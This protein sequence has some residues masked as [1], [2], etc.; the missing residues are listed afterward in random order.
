MLRAL[1]LRGLI[2]AP[3][4]LLALPSLSATGCSSTNGASGAPNSITPAATCARD[5]TVPPDLR[6]VERSG[7]G[8]VSTT[9]GEY[10]ARTPDWAR[11]GTVFSLLT[12]VW[13][14]TKSACPDLPKD[15]VKAL[16]AAV[17]SLKTSIAAKDQQ[18]AANA[19]NAVGI[20]VPSLFEYFN[21]DIPVE[22]VRMDATFRQ[23]G[24]DAHFGDWT[25]EQADVASLKADW[26]NSKAAVEKRVPTCHRV[27]GTAT[28]VGD[29]DQSIAN[30]EP[31]SA[32]MDAKTG[33]QESENGA[34]Q[35]DTLELLFDCPP[36][37]PAPKTG[38]GAACKTA[39]DCTSGEVCDMANKGGTCAPDPANAGIG[40]LCSTTNDCGSDPRS[41]CNTEAGDNFP[42]GYCGMEP[43]DDVQVC[44]PGGTCVS[45][46]HETPGCWKSCT[47]DAECRT[48]EGYV[49]Q[50]FPINPNPTTKDPAGFGPSATACGFPCTDD[51]GCT[52]PLKCNAATGKCNP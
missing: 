33:E 12:K 35:I 3:L 38:L 5:G 6:D 1:T 43:C 9:F 30:L 23:V 2:A 21:P 10:P 7:E 18:G 15:P 41:A 32:A 24:L 14:K 46:P 25:A 27:G 44:P 52:S 47:K 49:C 16:D 48:K 34:L 13:D 36:D 28:I 22:V 45:Q 29:I 42:G 19:A 8:L 37:G 17:A 40:T 51:A 11:A 50:L 20:A 39:S 4:A 26:A 31:V